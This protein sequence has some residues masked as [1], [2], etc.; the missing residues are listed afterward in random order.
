MKTR[1][2]SFLTF[3]L[4][5]FG[6]GDAPHSQR[7][8]RILA[9]GDSLMAAHGLSNRA[10]SDVVAKQLTQPVVDR[11]VLGARMIYNLPLT[12]AAGLS[13]PQQYR[14][15]EWDWVIVN[16]GGND[17]WL[18]CGC[19]A[20]RAKMDKLISQDGRR[21]KIPGL[22]NT[23]R[24]DGAKVV[25]V[26]YLRSPGLGSPIEHCRDE[27]NELEARIAKLAELDNG[28]YF[29]SN[30]DLVPHGDRSFHGIDMIHPSIKASTAIG[31]RISELIRSAEQ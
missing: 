1:L 28:L 11:S 29:L 4:V 13:I 19:F 2:I 27:G 8:A 15:G 6:C 17:L 18:G 22:L 3:V 24:K 31:E 26:G 7:E 23:L 25:Y 14:A 10:I 9:M 16:G 21:G 5:L 30:A 12:G 20:C